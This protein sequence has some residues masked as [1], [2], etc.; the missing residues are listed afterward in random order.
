MCF[1]VNRCTIIV[2]CLTICYEKGPVATMKFPWLQKAVQFI[3]KDTNDPNESSKL[4]VVVRVLVLSIFFYIVLNSIIYIGMLNN[5]GITILCVS[6]L[7]YLYIF[8]MSYHHKTINVVYALNLCTIAW[9]IVN[10]VYFGWDIGVQHFLLILLVLWFYSGYSQYQF[11]IFVASFLCLL[12]I[13][14]F[15]FC[16]LR[17][18]V[19]TLPVM[20]INILQ[21]INTIAIFWCISVI[22]YIFSRDSQALEG[23]LIDYNNQLLGQANTDALTGLY[24]RRKAM[25]Y[26]GEILVPSNHEFTS[27]CICDIDFFK[28]VNDNY[29][30]DVGD[31]VLQ[32]IAKTMKT[33]LAQKSFIA[34]WGGEE[35]L[36][37]FPSCNGD[38]ALYLLEELKSNIKSLQFHVGEKTFSVAMT[39]GLMEYDFHS[40]IDSAIKEAD[41]KL[42]M[43][44]ENG[45][46]QIVF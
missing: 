39:F 31:T 27:I 30:H 4:I 28:K 1:F 23:K 35:F 46:D 24:N 7:M 36:L 38:E 32:D 15:F 41:E 33:T 11:K 16:R 12:R 34:R 2:I 3:N 5:I 14:L 20:T 43:G 45:R 37:V 40:D 21:I 8:W 17:E 22:V 44:K 18:P 10:L 25:E 19:V 26:L 42:Y 13:Y 9:T 29:G 6:C